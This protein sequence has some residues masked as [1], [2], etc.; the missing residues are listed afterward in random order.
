MTEDR[1][2]ILDTA[3]KSHN[4]YPHAR[5]Y[6]DLVFVTSQVGRDPET[7]TLVKGG[8]EPEF[9]Q[10]LR[11]VETIVTAAGSSLKRVLNATVVLENEDDV[12]AMNRIY[13]ETFPDLW[14]ARTTLITGLPGTSCCS[15]AVMAARED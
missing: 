1:M 12:A 2:L 3:P 9:R 14:P 15:I 6:N 8:F 10:A 4:N 11:N 5:I 13:D 7:G